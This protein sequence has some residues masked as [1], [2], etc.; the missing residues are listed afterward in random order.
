MAAILDSDPGHYAALWLS[1]LPRGRAV[2]QMVGRQTEV[3]AVGAD[4]GGAETAA[5]TLLLSRARV[6]LDKVL[7]LLLRELSDAVA[8]ECRHAIRLTRALDGCLFLG[9]KKKYK[10]HDGDVSIFCKHSALT[11]NAPAVTIAVKHVLALD[12]EEGTDGES[13][14]SNGRKVPNLF[15]HAASSFRASRR[16][17]RACGQTTPTFIA[18]SRRCRYSTVEGDAMI[19]ST[20]EALC[21][22]RTRPAEITAAGHS[23]Q[24]AGVAQ[25]VVI[26]SVTPS[27]ERQRARVAQLASYPEW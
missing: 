18:S 8:L 3:T 7:R 12:L 1:T 19:I 9:D 24:R 20:A 25:Q 10:H 17:V 15:L 27:S 26:S 4:P 22:Q 16:H 21:V 2:A 11:N 23:S 5:R 13:E 6:A 14:E